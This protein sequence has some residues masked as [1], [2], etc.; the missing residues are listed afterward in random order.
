MNLTTAFIGNLTASDL[1]GCGK[2]L[3]QLATLKF[4]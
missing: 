4:L 2:V 1:S 3:N